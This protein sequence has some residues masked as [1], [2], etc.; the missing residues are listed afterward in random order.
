MKIL[1]KGIK[2]S[3]KFVSC[4][5]YQNKNGQ[6]TVYANNYDGFGEEV[7]SMFEVKNATDT[8]TD[9]WEKDHFDVQE[10]H[11]LYSEF[12]IKINGYSSS[13]EKRQQNKKLKK[14]LLIEQIE[15][16][17]IDG[18]VW[19]VIKSEPKKIGEFEGTKYEVQ[20]L[21]RPKKTYFAWKSTDGK[22]Y[23]KPY[24]FSF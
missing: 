17:K 6:I 13:W 5:Y 20:K 23:Q 21:F 14:A 24:C 10:D 3:G 11:P 4:Y 15:T 2:E 22:R 12:L 18:K 9:Y 16:I 1:Q 8:M 19:K 7:Q